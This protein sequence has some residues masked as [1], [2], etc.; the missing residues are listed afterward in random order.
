MTAVDIQYFIDNEQFENLDDSF[1]KEFKS[2]GFY[3]VEEYKNITITS[4]FFRW[5]FSKAAETIQI[6]HWFD[7]TSYNFM[8]A[9]YKPSLEDMESA[10]QYMFKDINSSVGYI[11]SAQAWFYKSKNKPSLYLLYLWE[12]SK[13]NEEIQMSKYEL[14]LDAL[15][16]IQNSD[17]ATYDD[18]VTYYRNY[19]HSGASRKY[20]ADP[21]ALV[22]MIG[23]DE[24]MQSLITRGL[25]SESEYHDKLRSIMTFDEMIDTMKKTIDKNE[26]NIHADVLNFFDDENYN[27]EQLAVIYEVMMST[28]YIRPYQSAL[29]KQYSSDELKALPNLAP[30]KLLLA[31]DGIENVLEE[32]LKQAKRTSI[33]TA[34]SMYEK[35]QS[36]VFLRNDEIAKYAQFIDPEA[37]KAEPFGYITKD[38]FKI[39]NSSS[40]KRQRWDENINN[41]R[42]ILYRHSNSDINI[43]DFEY[44]I[45]ETG[46]SNEQVLGSLTT[47]YL[48]ERNYPN[49]NIKPIIRLYKALYN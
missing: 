3:E 25:P 10:I 42:E 17:P 4:A 19:W 8:M 39:M 29:M 13:N 20:E 43:D 21:D 33:W 23:K 38:T 44:L 31:K 22:H 48:N 37:F 16:E 24:F 34:K 15:I 46:V 35:L 18:M 26:N 14:T 1:W 11:S 9:K 41:F 45:K 30:E 49:L 28:R 36:T 7:D 40:G 47:L 2:R 32:Y 5:Y 6:S 27:E 12:Q